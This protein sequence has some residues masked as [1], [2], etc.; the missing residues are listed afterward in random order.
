MGRTP[1]RVHGSSQEE[2]LSLQDEGLTA[3]EPG[4]VV[5]RSGA[6]EFRDSVGTFDPRSGS[7]LSETQHRNL[8]QLVHDVA[9]NSFVE[10]IRTGNKVT[11]VNT[12]TSNAKTARIR[13]VDFTYT[14]NK[15]TGIVTRQYGPDGT[16]VLETLTETLVYSGNDLTDITA[17]KT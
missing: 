12:W 15:V 10:Y 4:D 8:D 9:E 16:T 3:D 13:K 5:F 2:K 17:V 6:F 11:A 14:G 7:G 1:D